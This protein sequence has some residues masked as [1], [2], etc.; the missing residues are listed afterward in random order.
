[1]YLFT[2]QKWTQSQKTNVWLPQGKRRRDKLRIWDSQI[3]TSIHKID[4]L[5]GPTV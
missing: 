3:H 1:M 4:K 5:H 2:E